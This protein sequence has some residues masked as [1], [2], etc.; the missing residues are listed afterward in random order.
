MDWT[1]DA[2]FLLAL[3]MFPEEFSKKEI[4]AGTGVMLAHVPNHVAAAAKISGNQCRD[5][6][7]ETPAPELKR[8]KR[9]TKRRTVRREARRP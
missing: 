1:S 3:A 9:P 8:G 5:I 7:K 6:W 4:D 2:A